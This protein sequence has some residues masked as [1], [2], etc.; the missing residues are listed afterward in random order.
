MSGRWPT[1]IALA[2]GLCAIGFALSPATAPAA[3]VVPVATTE[4]AVV[5]VGVPEPQPGP[6]RWLDLPGL[7]VAAVVRPVGVDGDG[8]L[9]VPD[10]P[11][12]VGWWRD[13]ALPGSAAGT[14]VLDGHVDTHADGPGALFRITALRPGDAVQVRAAGGEYG[15]VVSAV[16]RYPK[17]ELPA[18]VFDRAGPPRLVLI[19]CGG[20]FDR[21]LR[22]YADNVVVYAVPAV[23][24]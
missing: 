9:G 13:G 3:G 1:W 10:D 16:R 4:R 17:A 6:P 20:A 15:Y 8:G 24:R 7:G 2:A 23:D 11:A 21:R 19:S 14:V 12:E 18:D 22:H 5:P